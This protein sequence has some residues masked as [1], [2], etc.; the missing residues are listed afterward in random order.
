MSRN[1]PNKYGLKRTA[2]GEACKKI[3]GTMTRQR[4]RADL[5]K[6]CK[7]AIDKLCGP[8]YPG[9]YAF[10]PRRAR[11]LMAHRMM[12]NRYKQQTTG[13]IVPTAENNV[14]ILGY[15]K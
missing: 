11:R 3:P 7:V 1:T 4:R 6:E 10:E 12:H 5:L 9:A 2:Q 15:R 14:A 8:P 13:V